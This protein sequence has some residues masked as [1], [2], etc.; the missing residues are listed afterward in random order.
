MGCSYCGKRY[1][2]EAELRQFVRAARSSR[3]CR[4]I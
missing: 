4:P 2:F 1:R 3:R